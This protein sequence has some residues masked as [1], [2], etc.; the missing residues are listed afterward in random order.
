MSLLKVQL[1]EVGSDRR[2]ALKAQPITGSLHEIFLLDETIIV[3]SQ[4]IINGGGMD[5]T[6]WLNPTN[7]LAQYWA[8][9]GNL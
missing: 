3:P 7:G 4:L 5:T 1:I 2:V 9:F 6:D 8:P